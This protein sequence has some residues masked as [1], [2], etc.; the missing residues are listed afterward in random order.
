[1]PAAPDAHAKKFLDA[2]DEFME[3]SPRLPDGAAASLKELGQTLRG[4]TDQ[5]Q[6]PGE[7]AARA[8]FT[9]GTG[10]HYSRAATGQDQP[11]PGQKEFM[12][13]AAAMVNGANK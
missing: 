8:A 9:N 1:M 3:S 12:A 10:E 11:S 13:A 7:K 4:Y 5:A 6:S 2:I